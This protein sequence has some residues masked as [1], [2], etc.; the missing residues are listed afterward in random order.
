MGAP[1]E[2]S[3]LARK[4]TWTAR[5]DLGLPLDRCTSLTAIGVNLSSY[6]VGNTLFAERAAFKAA[7]MKSRV[8]ESYALF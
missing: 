8:E 6:P 5:Q 2:L 1:L 7:L 3:L 4:Q